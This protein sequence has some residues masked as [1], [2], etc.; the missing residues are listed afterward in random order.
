[1]RFALSVYTFLL[2]LNIIFSS[3]AGDNLLINSSF[4]LDITG[5]DY[6]PRAVNLE[7]GQY[8][9]YWYGKIGKQKC[10]GYSDDADTGKRSLTLTGI[11]G[12]P[13]MIGTRMFHALPGEYTFSCKTKMK[14]GGSA[15]FTVNVKSNPF[16]CGQHLKTFQKTFTVNSES[17]TLNK[18]SFNLPPSKDNWRWLEISFKAIPGETMLLDSLMI[19]K[20]KDNSYTPLKAVEMNLTLPAPWFK[21]YRKGAVPE[22]EINAYNNWDKDQKREVEVYIRDFEN[23]IIFKKQIKVEVPAK[24]RVVKK[25]A[26]KLG[27]LQGSFRA[28]LYY[29]NKGLVID[30]QNFAVLPEIENPVL[31]TQNE[32]NTPN[33]NKALGIVYGGQHNAGM[34]DRAEPSPGKFDWGYLDYSYSLQGTAYKENCQLMLWRYSKWSC[35]KK[36]KKWPFPPSAPPARQF[37]MVDYLNFIEKVSKRYP[38][39]KYIQLWNEPWSWKPAEFV[40]FLKICSPRIKKI[41]PEIKILA[42]T[43]FPRQYDWTE[44]FIKAGGLKYTDIFAVH[45]YPAG[46]GYIPETIAS[47]IKWGHADGNMKR[48]IWNTETAL[49]P[50]QVMSWYTFMMPSN[51]GTWSDRVYIPDA[52]TAEEGAERW[53]KMYITQ[54]AMGISRF[55]PHVAPHTQSILPRSTQLCQAEPDCSRYPQGIVWSVAGIRIGNAVAL[56]TKDI[57]P[58]LRVMLFKKGQKLEAV[59]WTREYENLQIVDPIGAKLYRTYDDAVKNHRGIFR[60]IIPR[61]TYQYALKLPAAATE[62]FDMHG[63]KIKLKSN[64]GLLEVP[65]SCRPVYLSVDNIQEK[66]LCD[67]LKSGRII[68][69]KDFSSQAGVGRTSKGKIGLLCKVD[70]CVDENLTIKAKSRTL[71]SAFSLK[72]SIV[73][74]RLRPKRSRV[75]EFEFNKYPDCTSAT[76]GF[77]ISLKS[78]GYKTKIKLSR[79]WMLGAFKRNDI[80]VDGDISEWDN[81][82]GIKLDSPEQAVVQSVNWKGTKDSSAVMKAAWNK[83]Y[84]YFAVSVRDDE[85]LERRGW[86]GDCVELFFDFD[87]WGDKNV[88]GLNKDDF[89]IFANPPVAGKWP[90]GTIKANKNMKGAILRAKK[91]PYGYTAEIALPVK[92]FSNS[93]FILRENQVIGFTPT[94]C[95]FDSNKKW[96]KLVWTGAAKVHQDTSKFGSMVLLGKSS[97]NTK[98]RKIENIIALWKFDNSKK[99]DAFGIDAVNAKVSNAVL[100]RETK[101]L[102]FNGYS[103]IVSVPGCPVSANKKLFEMTIKAVDIDKK[104]LLWSEA[105]AP[106]WRY[107]GELEVD[108]KLSFSLISI[109]KVYWKL[110]S[111]TNI[112]DDKWH[113]IGYRWDASKGIIQL[114]I[115]G[116]VERHGKLKIESTVTAFDFGGSTKL[117]RYFK[118]FI[119]KVIISN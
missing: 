82:P 107:L 44:G 68:G 11:V 76:G 95:D 41:N 50:Y 3:N 7:N 92:L 6:Q 45:A 93:G 99:L 78:A 19:S 42:P 39:F 32:I 116:K 100:D 9:W 101:S 47:V 71:S 55:F 97:G 26:V 18:F 35:A 13:L 80:D 62:A 27:D 8:L 96:S 1:M 110:T 112:L 77:D 17:W 46:G 91:Q 88:T 33:M 109:N 65:I 28:E 114:I 12:E 72:K 84:L 23:R 63:N 31:A 118:G 74:T 57:N 24:S 104:Q 79:V 98:A 115:D 113:K 54:T 48:P 108:G 61:K 29:A 20:S 87:L 58:N 5:R 67:I 102:A 106:G 64:K 43:I 38:K 90:N 89:Q 60:K 40:E 73:K 105:I 53:A 56:G 59:I 85:L 111:R 51:T 70:S 34:W 36:D 83:E 52:H 22:L 119:Q 117:N 15:S 86:S 66:Q 75:I 30:Q 49:H 21:V 69:F 94:V 103:S 81:I 16:T 25:A 10:I 2:S 14:S 4:E 37:D